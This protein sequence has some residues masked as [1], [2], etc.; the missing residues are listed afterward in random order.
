MS[1]HADIPTPPWRTPPRPQR[2][3][4]V[5]QPLTRDGIVEVAMRIVDAEGIDGLSMRRIAQELDTGP[6]SLYAHVANKEELLE[7]LLDRVAE[8]VDVPAPDPTGWQKQLRRVARDLHRT[9]I[10]HADIA[11][12]ALANIPTGPNAL[13]VSE[14]MLA[15]MLAAGLPPQIASWALDRIFLYVTADAFESSLYIAKVR[16]SGQTVEEY[17]GEFFDQLGGFYRALPADRFPA[18]AANVDALMSGD[19]DQRFEFGLD[20]LVDGLIRYLP[21]PNR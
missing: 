21:D 10:E 14:G 19:G 20:M 5:R 9:L 16:A 6:S 7:L 17:L 13:R 4:P 11:R 18:I 8:G 15:I 1:T 3:R 12:A 2:D